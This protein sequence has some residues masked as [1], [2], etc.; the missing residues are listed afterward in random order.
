MKLLALQD[1]KFGH[2]SY[3]YHRNRGD[4]F[5]AKHQYATRLIQA[6]KARAVSDDE[7]DRLIADG[8]AKWID[9]LRISNKVWCK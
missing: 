7:A 2:F 1:L 6:G 8:Q 3:R 9:H 5:M 4:I